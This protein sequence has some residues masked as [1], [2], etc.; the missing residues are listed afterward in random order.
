MTYDN[1]Q[2]AH[3]L[4]VSYYHEWTGR[5]AIQC[6]GQYMQKTI[7]PE[8]GLLHVTSMQTKWILPDQRLCDQGVENGHTVILLPLNYGQSQQ[9]QQTQQAQQAQQ[10]PAPSAKPEHNKERVMT[11]VMPKNDGPPKKYTPRGTIMKTGNVTFKPGN[12]TPKT[13]EQIAHEMQVTNQELEKLIVDLK[14]FS[15]IEDIGHGAFGSLY[16]AKEPSSGRVYAVKIMT[17]DFDNNSKQ[18]EMF[19]REVRILASIGHPCVL[20]FRGFVPY[21][22]K[23]DHPAILTEYMQGGSLQAL[24][25][26]EQKGEHCP[27]WDDTHKLIVIYGVAVGMMA[28][29]SKRIIHRDLKPDNVLLNDS[30]EPKVADFGLS[31]FVEQGATQYQ[32]LHGG[33]AA[34]MAPEIYQESAYDFKVDVYAFGMLVYCVLTGLTP[35]QDCPTPY[36]VGTK[37]TKGYRPPLPSYL[38]ESWKMLISACWEPSPEQRPTFEQI[39]TELATPN[40]MGGGVRPDLFIAYQNKVNVPAS[41][42]LAPTK[43]QNQKPAQPTKTKT[44][45]ELLK[46]SAD[47]GDAF[48]QNEYGIKLRD[49]VGVEKDLEKACQYFKR[50]AQGGNPGGMVNYGKCLLK[51]KGCKKDTKEGRQWVKKAADRGDIN[52]CYCYAKCLRYGTGGDKDW[53]EAARLMKE[54]ADKGHDGAQ[55]TYG[56]ALEFQNF[57]VKRDVR[58]SVRYYKMSSDQ[59]SLKGMYFYADML[60]EGKGVE[61]DTAEALRLYRLAANAGHTQSIGYLGVL[62]IHGEI[63]PQDIAK[64]V[65]M[66]NRQIQMG[67]ET[68]YLRLG[69]EYE[70]GKYLKKDEAEAY[71]LYDKA[72]VVGQLQIARCL[73][74]GIGCAKEPAK[75]AAIY[76]MFVSLGEERTS[77]TE[78][79]IMYY[80]GEGVDK[81]V[82]KGLGLITKAAGLGER[83]AQMLLE[84]KAKGI[85]IEIAALLTN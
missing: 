72:G 62:Y 33:T 6:A 71:R 59:G 10:Q 85:D 74:N 75:A 9:A 13:P 51:G 80:R 29:H 37:V 46:E 42:K 53:P 57:G 12:F 79:G 2:Y 7:T 50:S 31:K 4:N 63:V 36:V 23:G 15:K 67:D 73:R 56:L 32:T 65:S 66:I 47:D 39:V 14:A 68:G 61:K 41:L 11:F 84:A 26:K 16:T 27:K 55:A 44:A 30:L 18:L 28:L 22:K 43:S 40:F 34:F 49:G 24:L 83:K 38:D 54:A 58:E 35:F 77:M 76:L 69:K 1:T 19:M 64:G 8:M 60:E 5:D 48:A 3:G 70:T 81:D 21:R 25:D 20:S 45:L 78:L 82:E 52:G 17:Q